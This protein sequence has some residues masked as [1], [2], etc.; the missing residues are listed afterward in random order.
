MKRLLSVI[1]VVAAMF[2]VAL[3]AQAAPFQRTYFGSAASSFERDSFGCGS[4]RQVEIVRTFLLYHNGHYVIAKAG[5][6]KHQKRIVDVCRF[7]HQRPLGHRVVTPKAPYPC[8][9]AAC[10]FPRKRDMP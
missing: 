5:T 1:A 7:L 2:A 3:P 6:V 9:P 10:P 8:D 4:G